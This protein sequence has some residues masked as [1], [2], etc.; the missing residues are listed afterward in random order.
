MPE[1]GKTWTPPAL[2]KTSAEYLAG[3]GVPGA[4]LDAELLLCHALG[5]GKRL[6]LYTGF[7][8]PLEESELAAYRELVR[9]RAAREPVS[10]ILGRR[11]F[12][13]LSFAVTPDVLA[14]R[15]ETEIL[16]EQ[17]LALLSPPRRKRSEEYFAR[18]EAA[19]PPGTAAAEIEPARVAESGPADETFSPEERP[20]SPLWEKETLKVLDLC[21]GSGCIAAAVAAMCPRARVVATDVSA[22]AL[23]VAEKNAAAAGVAERIEFRR[24]DMF[25]ACVA[26]EGFDLVLSNP[27]YLVE[28]DPAIWPEVRDYEPALALYGGDDGLDFQRI[29]ANETEKWLNPGGWLLVE[30][31]CGQAE[32]VQKLLGAAT[33]LDGIGAVRDHCGIDR[34]VAARKPEL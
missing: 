20:V 29:I 34:V 16:V 26:G 31:G 6:E 5:A 33:L 25:A 30:V 1:K 11:E 19:L 2:V 18:L 4:K 15:P 12:M 17:A 24:G 10:H 22:A 32:A 13:G 21:T 9:R 3:K 27:P 28:G 14:P 8:R 23:A 7:D